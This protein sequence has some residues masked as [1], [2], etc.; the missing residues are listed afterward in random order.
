MPDVWLV[1]LLV[2]GDLADR[3]LPLTHDL[4]ELGVRREALI[5][6]ATRML[7]LPRPGVADLGGLPPLL[8]QAG[9]EEVLLDDAVALADRAKAAGVEDVYFD[10]GG[11]LFHG[12]VKA[13]AD[14]ARE[15][16]LKF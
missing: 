3:Q 14:A 10:R 9:S 12:K 6:P 4:D 8:V 7:P 13:L 11:F 5:V 16:G 2:E 15:G 1:V